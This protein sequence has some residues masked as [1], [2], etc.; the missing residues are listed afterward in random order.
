VQ[1]RSVR[2]YTD[3][4]ISEYMAAAID[5]H[6][7]LPGGPTAGGLAVGIKLVGKPRGEPMLFAQAAIE[8]RLVV[9][10]R[11]PSNRQKADTPERKASTGFRLRGLPR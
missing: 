8:N 10:P 11:I 4:E 1:L 5:A 9:A 2:I 7:T 3:A 6:W